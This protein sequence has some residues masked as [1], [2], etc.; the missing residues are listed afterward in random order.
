MHTYIRRSIGCSKPP[1]KC[2]EL[3]NTYCVDVLVSN[4]IV[5]SLYRLKTAGKRT[6]LNVSCT[7]K[8]TA[9]TDEL[10]RHLSCAI[11][12][13]HKTGLLLQPVLR[14]R[15][16]ICLPG[17]S[18]L[19]PCFAAGP[20]SGSVVL[21][22]PNAEWA[23]S[24]AQGRG[25]HADITRGTDKA[26]VC[27]VATLHGIRKCSILPVCCSIQEN[28]MFSGCNSC[29]GHMFYAADA[30]Y[31]NVAPPFRW[32]DRFSGNAQD[33]SYKKQCSKMAGHMIC[34]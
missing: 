31:A 6:R 12:P 30:F 23:D 29:L 15:D 7:E 17:T 21:S 19:C 25:D 9:A 27:A 5:S 18:T 13:R 1:F 14:I 16:G 22:A 24:T 34:V 2:L 33:E 8:I 10:G 32:P 11:Q 20:K 26:A 4:H 28:K 3:V